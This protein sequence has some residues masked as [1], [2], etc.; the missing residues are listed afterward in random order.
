MWHQRC[1]SWWMVQASFDGWVSLGIHIDLR[2]RRAANG[3]RYG[4]YVDLHL[5]CVIVS[6]G[7]NPAYS[8]EIGA[9]SSVSR[10]GLRAAER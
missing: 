10:G 9:A 4:P 5:G 1:A 6:L 3:R 7:V 2:R 8:G